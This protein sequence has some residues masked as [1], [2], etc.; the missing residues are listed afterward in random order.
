MPPVLLVLITKMLS[1]SKGLHPLTATKTWN[2]FSTV[3]FVYR[4]RLLTK[5]DENMN[6]GIEK[7]ES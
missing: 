1:A 4:E 7:F 5:I 3:N 6:V 2:V